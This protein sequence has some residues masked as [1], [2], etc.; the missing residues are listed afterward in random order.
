MEQR[1]NPHKQKLR[2][3][4]S[5]AGQGEKTFK[6][7]VTKKVTEE[8]TKTFEIRAENEAEAY[9]KVQDSIEDDGLEEYVND[10]DMPWPTV[11]FDIDS[12]VEN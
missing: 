1:K 7:T 9:R 5:G 11:D 12:V 4:G 10:W 3:I 2:K 8:S 6:I